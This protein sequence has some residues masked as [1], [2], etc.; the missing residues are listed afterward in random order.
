MVRTA[1]VVMAIAIASCAPHAVAPR[2]NFADF[3]AAPYDH[4]IERLPPWTT[5]EL[6]GRYTIK[7]G[8]WI[9]ELDPRIE[10]HGQDGFKEFVEAADEGTFVRNRL[11]P[12][13][14]CFKVSAAGFRSMLGT[15]VIDPT[16]PRDVPMEIQL[17]ISE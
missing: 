14:Y 16:L 5:A 2:C 9:P 4:L 12:G 6:R 15:V 7:S 11:K 8:D 17:I 13:S 1:V 3:E 10:L